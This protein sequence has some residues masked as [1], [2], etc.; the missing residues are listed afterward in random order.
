MANN[1]RAG[2]NVLWVNENSL[3]DDMLIVALFRIFDTAS[4]NYPEQNGG[5]LNRH[6]AIRQL[7]KALVRAI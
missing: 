7:A 2:D 5:T 4:W 3:G 1:Y 6:T